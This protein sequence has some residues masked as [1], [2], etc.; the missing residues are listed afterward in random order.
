M[1]SVSQPLSAAPC[2]LAS[3]ASESDIKK[4]SRGQPFDYSLF[5]AKSNPPTEEGNQTE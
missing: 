3:A 1:R 4:K 5:Q 2:P